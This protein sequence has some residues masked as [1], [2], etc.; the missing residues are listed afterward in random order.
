MDRKDRIKGL[1]AGMAARGIT[2]ALI[3]YSRNILYYTGTAQPSWLVVLPGDYT[4]YVRSGLDFALNDVFIPREKVREER[5]L[6]RIGEALSV[7]AQGEDR[8]LGVEMDILTAEQFRQVGKCFP[9][10]EAV[11]V[12]SL[13]LDQRKKKEPAEIEKIRKACGAIHA[14]HEAVL[15]TLREGITELELAAAVENAHRLAGHEGIFFIRQPDFF[16]SRGPISSG[17]NLFRISG[18]VYTITGVGL[19]PAVPA[20]PSR[21]KIEAGDIVI[22]DIPTLVDGY[23]A[24]QTRTYC[25]GKAGKEIHSLY[26]DLR[27]IADHLI[28]AIRP[29]IACTEVYRLAVEKAGELGR[30]ETFQHFGGGKISRLI[31]HGIGLELNEPPILS[32]YDASPLEEGQ[33]V[34]LDLHMLDEALGVVKLEDMIHIRAKRNEILTTTPR[35]LFEV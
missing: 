22:V 13:P 17:P 5:R 18:V 31:G 8:R 28:A 2:A 4:L 29:G 24:D 21:R 10:F 12:S 19:S 27:S 7:P 25:L 32:G 11:D 3:G 14:G 20:G 35:M 1:Q 6:E 9:G 34:A 26:D 33:V 16:M 23:H 30:R 15:S